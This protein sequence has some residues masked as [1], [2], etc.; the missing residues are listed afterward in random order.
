MKKGRLEAHIMAKHPSAVNT[1]FRS[2]KEKFEKRQT[3]TNMFK[4]KT[5]SAS[6]NLEASYEISL[7]IAKCGQNH[8]L[9]EKLIKPSISIFS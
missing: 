4:T 1:D 8:T 7:L 6:R 9:G 2:L 3:I 5:V